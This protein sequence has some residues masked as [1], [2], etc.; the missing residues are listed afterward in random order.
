MQP[1]PRERNEMKTRNT[2]PLLIMLIMAG[3]TRAE[4]VYL[5]SDE[6]LAASADYCLFGTMIHHRT[7]A[8][9]ERVFGSYHPAQVDLNTL[10]DDRMLKKGAAVLASFVRENLHPWYEEATSN[11]KILARAMA[12][13]LPA[14]SRRGRAPAFPVLATSSA[15]SLPQTAQTNSR[16]TEERQWVVIPVVTAGQLTVRLKVRQRATLADENWLGLEFKNTGHE[17]IKVSGHRIWYS[18]TAERFNLRSGAK[19][20]SGSLAGGN[21]VD[22]FPE[23]WTSKPIAPL[24][25]APG[26]CSVF[27]QPSDC[28]AALLGLPSQD[29]L[30]VRAR[31][32]LGI[33]LE[34]DQGVSTSEAGV[35]FSFE[36]VY[37]DEA[38][39]AAMRRRLRRLLQ[40]PPPKSWSTCVRIR[41][42][43]LSI[44]GGSEAVTAEELLAAMNHRQVRGIR[45]GLA[46]HISQHL[47]RT[48]D[49][50]AY[51]RQRLKEKDS[52][53]IEDLHRCGGIWHEDFLETL[54]SI[55]ENDSGMPGYHALLALAHH[56]Q[57]WPED[58]DIPTR[59]STVVLRWYAVL[60]RKPDELSERDLVERWQHAARVLALA[61]DKTVIPLLRPYLDCR[62]RVLPPDASIAVDPDFLQYPPPVRVCDV[63]LE[64]ILTLLSDDPCDTYEQALKSRM[65]SAHP[66]PKPAKAIG[67]APSPSSTTTPAPSLLDGWAPANQLRDE[68]IID[69]KRR[70]DG[71]RGAD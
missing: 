7:L 19:V 5:H 48:P 65:L 67:P 46:K 45:D 55:C 9:H 53:A 18:M 63:A 12:T 24:I 54:L 31:V 8:V 58:S 29:G 36:W 42:A 35:P 66:G 56:Y 21:C 10:R 33:E 28:S 64:A 25:I 61:G 47:G 15:A 62:L 40:D 22:L 34:E 49:V 57:H 32:H 71:W 23:L 68:M 27:A 43:L 52:A 4:T 17:S 44:P 38:G 30:L 60:L 39:F 26:A 6:E 20:C 13:T 69:L 37:P 14:S 59:V 3:P 41:D 51:Y 50:I 70:L 16:P 2:L 1:W 11:S